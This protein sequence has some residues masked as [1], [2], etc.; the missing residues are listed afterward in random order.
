VIVLETERLRL[1][2]VTLDDAPFIVRLLNDAAWLEFI[3]DRGVRTPEDA[4][5]YLTNGPIK[6]QREHGFALWVVETKSDG[7]PIGVC[8][9]LKRPTLEDVDLGYAFLPEARGRGYAVEAGA[10]TLAHGRSAHGLRRIIALTAPKNARSIHVLGKL[11]FRFERTIPFPTANDESHLFA[12]EK[13]AHQ[14]HDSS[15]R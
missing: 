11:G 7:A 4:R 3:G 13:H 14:S 2:E 6:M 9:L 8:G 5:A 12:W 10:A 1:R 15:D